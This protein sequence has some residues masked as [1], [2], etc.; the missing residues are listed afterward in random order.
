L[1]NLIKKRQGMRFEHGRNKLGKSFSV[2][3]MRFLEQKI[4]RY[5]FPILLQAVFIGDHYVK[6]HSEL[7]Y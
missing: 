7:N 2:N 3:K 1:E 5:D 4:S 6:N